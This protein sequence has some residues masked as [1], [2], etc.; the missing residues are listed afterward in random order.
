MQKVNATLDV[1]LSFH[2]GF[3]LAVLA[4]LHVVDIYTL[5]PYQ[6]DLLIVNKR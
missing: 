6:L 1:A 3:Y 4:Y 5:K 2:Y